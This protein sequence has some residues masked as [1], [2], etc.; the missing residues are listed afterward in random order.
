MEH[1]ILSCT[2]KG[3]SK[4]VGSK[5]TAKLTEFDI[6]IFDTQNETSQFLLQEANP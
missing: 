3:D 5:Q 4:A 6:T 2:R 1:A